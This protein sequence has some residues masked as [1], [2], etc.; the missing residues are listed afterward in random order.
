MRNMADFKNNG[1]KDFG[2]TCLHQEI[3]RVL[4]Q[5]DFRTSTAGKLASKFLGVTQFGRSDHKNI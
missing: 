2:G 1:F 4:R 5:H 3:G